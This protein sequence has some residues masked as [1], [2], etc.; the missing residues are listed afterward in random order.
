MEGSVSYALGNG[1]VYFYFHVKDGD[2]Q[3]RIVSTDPNYVGTAEVADNWMAISINRR[4]V[5][6]FYY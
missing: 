4:V 1:R 5:E 3:I 2:H 6:F